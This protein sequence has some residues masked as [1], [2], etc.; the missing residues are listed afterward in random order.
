M[1]FDKP[2]QLLI[3]GRPEMLS[4]I[5]QFNRN[6]MSL[7]VGTLPFITARKGLAARAKVAEAFENIFSSK[8][9][10]D[11]SALVKTYYETCLKNGVSVKDIARFEVVIAV[12][13][14][15][16]TAP[17]MFWILFHL[18]AQPNLLPELQNEVGQMIIEK[19]KKG[20]TMRSIDVTSLKVHCPLLT[21]TFQEV[22]RCRSVGTAVRQVMQDSILDNRWLHLG[23]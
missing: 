21:S 3:H 8:G 2:M 14:L 7:I 4:F 22:L 15:A 16:I 10:E 23:I 5:R 1:P 6:S 13:L 9:H 20:E 11:A 18:H 17:A 12:A 19:K